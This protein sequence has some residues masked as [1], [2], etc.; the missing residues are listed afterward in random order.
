MVTLSEKWGA[1]A[2]LPK[3]DGGPLKKIGAFGGWR[4]KEEWKGGSRERILA[5]RD[6]QATL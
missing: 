5:G 6:V 2:L 1:V 3:G 4:E